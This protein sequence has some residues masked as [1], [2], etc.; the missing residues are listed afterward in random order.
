M[1]GLKAGSVLVGWLL[2]AGCG[3][4]AVESQPSAEAPAAQAA[5]SGNRPPVIEEITFEPR[6]PRPG[7]RVTAHVVAN[8]PEG[9][10]LTIEYAWSAGGNPVEGTRPWI[11]LGDLQRNAAVTVTVT[12][13]DTAGGSSSNSATA[14]IGNT[15]PTLSK[16]LLS[17]ESGVHAGTDILA[18]PRAVDPEGDTLEFSYRWS[19]NGSTLPIEGATLPAGNFE[20]GDVVVLEVVASDGSD[21]T[22]PLA[23]EPIKVGNAP[24]RITSQNGKVDSDGVYRY[25]VQ[26]EDPDGDRAFRYRLLNGPPGMAIGF[27]DGQLRW[28]PPAD[29]A[30]PHPIEI[31]VQDLFG[32]RTT[33]SITLQLA[34]EAQPEAEAAPAATAATRSD[35][36]ISARSSKTWAARMA[37]EEAGGEPA[38]ASPEQSPD[39]SVEKAA[40]PAAADSE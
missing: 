8:D 11:Q 25:A 18:S 3:D 35:K 22:E 20:R 15:P 39:A 12:A 5:Q 24:P 6:S 29:A 9:D 27:D 34:Y 36:H 31:E 33:Q 14:R 23:S 10:A 38:E 13:T 1:R 4:D 32:G 19:V 17:P 28:D 21:V 2:L 30:G 40:P 37:E 26:V 16:V 7:E